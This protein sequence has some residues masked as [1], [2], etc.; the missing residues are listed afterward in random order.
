MLE[1]YLHLCHGHFLVGYHY[2]FGVGV[3]RYCHFFA[4]RCFF[5][6]FHLAE[7]LDYLFFYYSRV[8]IAYGYYSHVVRAVPV[9]VEIAQNFVREC[10]EH[11]FL[12]DGQTVGV[13][14]TCEHDR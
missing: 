7:T 5:R 9:V 1:H 11:F 13:F 10:F 3:V 6:V 4:F 12:T 8:E 2:R 14:G